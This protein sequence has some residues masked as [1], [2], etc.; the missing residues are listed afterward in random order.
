[1][2][3]VKKIWKCLLYSVCFI[4]GFVSLSMMQWLSE[5]NISSKS[6]VISPPLLH[7]RSYF[8]AV[9]L[10][11]VFY[12]WMVFIIMSVSLRTNQERKMHTES[13]I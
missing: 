12:Q 13:F 3:V 6:Q 5:N 9:Y 10:M 11:I 7:H 1:M 4:P 8:P 2:D